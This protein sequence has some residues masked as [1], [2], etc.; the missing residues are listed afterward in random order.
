MK[1]EESWIEESGVFGTWTFTTQTMTDA[2]YYKGLAYL[3]MHVMPNPMQVN[4]CQL[5]DND[6]T[7]KH[8]KGCVEASNHACIRSRNH[9]TDEEEKVE[10]ECVDTETSQLDWSDVTIFFQFG[11]RLR[12]GIIRKAYHNVNT[13]DDWLGPYNMILAPVVNSKTKNAKKNEESRE[14]FV[15]RYVTTPWTE[16][17]L[18]YPSS[19]ATI[20]EANDATIVDTLIGLTAINTTILEAQ[21]QWN[22]HHRLGS[23]PS[24][25]V[26]TTTENKV[27]LQEERNLRQRRLPQRQTN[28]QNHDQNHVTA[29]NDDSGDPYAK[30]FHNCNFGDIHPQLPRLELV[31][32]T[33]TDTTTGGATNTS[34][35]MRIDYSIVSVPEKGG[36]NKDLY[37]LWPSMKKHLGLTFPLMGPYCYGND[38]NRAYAIRLSYDSEIGNYNDNSSSTPTTTPSVWKGQ[39]GCVSWLPC[40]KGDVPPPSPSSPTNHRIPTHSGGGAGDYVINPLSGAALLLYVFGIL[41]VGS[42]IVNGVLSNRLTQLQQLIQLQSQSSSPTPAPPPAPT[43]SSGDAE[44][45]DDSLEEEEQS[46][47]QSQHLLPPK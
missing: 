30:Q 11:F 37:K 8:H 22:G 1:K 18:Q 14:V 26:G 4:S 28:D 10:E 43:P 3:L 6:P 21:K 42:C 12:T 40:W 31:K 24:R 36:I 32:R 47:S 38:P 25:V 7:K 19:T 2:G 23:R 35:S 20:F 34:Y 39:K 13:G 45:E 41:L 5:G 9:N 15:S 27:I 16:S 17:Q 33:I 44:D 46:Q 29:V